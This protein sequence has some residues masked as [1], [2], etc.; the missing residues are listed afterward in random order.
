MSYRT[1]KILF[2]TLAVS[3]FM[4]PT[5]NADIEYV[6]TEND[7]LVTV[8]YIDL[9]KAQM[10]AEIIEELA[11]GDLKADIEQL[12]PEAINSA[13]KNGSSY[14]VVRV[15]G[16]QTLLASASCEIILRSGVA[17][18][19]VTDETNIA[20]GIGLSDVT[21]GTEIIGGES[22]PQNHYIVIPR[23]DGRGVGVTSEEA[24]F[25]VRGEYTLVSE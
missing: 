10:K 17:V 14:E 5:V 4:M 19:V 16:G 23:A 12:D 6:S 15:E 2:C 21:A 18:A 20:S 24:Y 11:I 25:M 3:I 9:I 7:P 1:K 8:S 13:L 22:V